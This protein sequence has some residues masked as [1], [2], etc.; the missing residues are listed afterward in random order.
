MGFGVPLDEWF[1]G[2]LR[3]MLWDHLTAKRFLERGLVSP[4]FLRTLLE[5]HDSRRR[6][7]ETWLWSLRDQ[8]SS[9][10]AAAGGR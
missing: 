8:R 6:N 10:S 4:G 9:Q 2:P 1:R 7:N 5:E 3:S